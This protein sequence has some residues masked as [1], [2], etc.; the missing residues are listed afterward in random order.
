VVVLAQTLSSVQILEENKSLKRQVEELN[1]QLDRANENS[2]NAVMKEF[3]L[4]EKLTE[5]GFIKAQNDRLKR[6][7]LSLQEDLRLER[8]RVD[9]LTLRQQKIPKKFG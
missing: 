8:A 7:I 6:I 2:E 1:E 9:V 5:L 3:E 4:R